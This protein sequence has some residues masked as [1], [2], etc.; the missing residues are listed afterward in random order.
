MGKVNGK[1]RQLF[2]MD[3]SQV[4]IDIFLKGQ[5]LGNY[6]NRY[7]KAADCN[8]APSLFL[9]HF[10]YPEDVWS[11]GEYEYLKPSDCGIS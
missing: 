9:G 5:E 10:G 8:G 7:S 2:Q 6:A 3:I 11:L 4:T 1:M